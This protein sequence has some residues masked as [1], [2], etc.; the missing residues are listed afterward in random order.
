MLFRSVLI[1]RAKTLAVNLKKVQ[2]TIFPAHCLLDDEMQVRKVQVVLD[3]NLTP[4][5]GMVKGDAKK[6]W[7]Y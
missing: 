3:D 4:Y 1:V 7:H 2:M 5:Q 6:Q